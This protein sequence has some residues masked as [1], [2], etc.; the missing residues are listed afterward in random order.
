M[1][2]KLEAPM[3]GEAFR[4]SKKSVEVSQRD[5]QIQT[6]V[7]VKTDPLSEDALLNVFSGED[8]SSV[9]SRE[10]CK[11][12]MQSC[13]KVLRCGVCKAATY[14]SNN[15]QKEDWQFHKRVC[16]KAKAKVRCRCGVIFEDDARG[17]ATC[18]EERPDVGEGPVKLEK[19]ASIYIM[20][21]SI[22]RRCT[23]VSIDAARIKVHYDDFDDPKFDEWFSKSSDCILS[24]AQD[25][26]PSKS[27][28]LRPQGAQSVVVDDGEEVGDWYRHR[29]WRPEEKQEF[30]PARVET[31]QQSPGKTQ[32]IGSAWNAA[33]TWEERD[34]LQ[35]WKKRLL[36]LQIVDLDER[37]GA[38]FKQINEVTGHASIVH[39]RGTSRF[40]FDLQFQVEFELQCASGS[41][42]KC[43]L[44][45]TD[46]C[47]DSGVDFH[48]E[49][50]ALDPASSL[51]HSV[52]IP[53]LKIALR[54][55]ISEY[56]AL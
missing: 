14:C 53:E 30:R 20:K 35:W 47:N 9:G 16:K 26:A 23:I 50:E 40:L 17:C 41:A 48:T 46:F 10:T 19:G 12:C 51:I 8:D 56:E 28:P 22:P 15:C 31:E 21:H 44:S 34:M 1:S 25:S 45:A 24:G 13:T 37:E 42:S 4:E 38:T 7:T 36:S 5:L 54:K 55:C 18:G 32:T 11:N 43:Y 27:P 49:V 33:G 29:E 6:P 2:A 39:V 52:W 3:P